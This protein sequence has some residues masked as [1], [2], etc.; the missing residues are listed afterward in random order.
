MKVCWKLL[1][2]LRLNKNGNFKH[3]R[4]VYY[5][6]EECSV[7]GEDYFSAKKT[8]KFCSGK[9]SKSGENHPMYGTKLSEEHK[10]K[11]FTSHIR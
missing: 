3:D 9:C 11:L 7:C 5:Y 2:E 6:H 4:I 10:R 8:G 1:N